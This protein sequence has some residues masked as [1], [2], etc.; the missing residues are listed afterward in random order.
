MSWWETQSAVVFGGGGDGIGGQVCRELS[1]LG[2]LVTIVDRDFAAAK[3]CSRAC[4]NEAL[5]LK[6][7]T[8]AFS[9]VHGAMV[10]AKSFSQDHGRTVGLVVNNAGLTVAGGLEQLSVLDM[11]MLAA[12]NILGTFNVLK[13]AALSCQVWSAVVV[14]SMAGV[15]ASGNP[16]YDA[17]KAA[18]MAL[19]RSAIR[20]RGWSGRVNVVLPGFI[21]GPF[22]RREATEIEWA[23]RE[24][25]VRQLV[26]A[27]RQGR[28]EEVAKA[29]AF[30]LSPAASYI[31]GVCLPV[32]G[33]LNVL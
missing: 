7:D 5:P 4:Q 6:A 30:L 1:E 33:G 32:D 2:A 23:A 15:K 12:T 11:N 25:T 17:T 26:P 18:G 21:D 16:G 8:A 9:D 19:A 28:P 22:S 27:G 24:A 20:G 29:V 10:L 31:N 3:S 14:G 13:V